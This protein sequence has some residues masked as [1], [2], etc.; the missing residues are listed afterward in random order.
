MRNKLVKKENQFI[1]AGFT[2]KF[3]RPFLLGS[4]ACAGTTGQAFFIGIKGTLSVDRS[5]SVILH[6]AGL[7]YLR[8]RVA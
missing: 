2:H 3:D 5:K 6:K 1:R 7:F 8:R 4:L